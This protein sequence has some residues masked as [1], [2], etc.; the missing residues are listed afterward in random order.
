MRCGRP[1]T[2]PARRDLNRMVSAPTEGLSLRK[3][4]AWISLGEG[5]DLISQ[6]GLLAVLSKL[7]DVGAVGLFGLAM[8]VI[9]PVTQLFDLGLRKAQAT[10]V[11]RE[12]H[13]NHYFSLRVVTSSVALLL[14]ILVGSALGVSAY[15]WTVVFLMALAKVI[16]GQSDVFHGLF[17]HHSRMDYIA[18][19]RM[20]RGPL[21]LTLFTLG[22]LVTG[23]QRV[24]SLGLIVA[25]FT[26][27][28]LND[29]RLARRFLTVDG[30]EGSQGNL[31]DTGPHKAIAF[32]WDTKRMSALV[33]QVLPLGI[34]AL[35]ASLQMN[36]P[37]YSLEHQLGLEALGYF[38]AVSVLYS[39]TARMAN[40]IA[41]SASASMARGFA[42]GDRRS[43][44]LLYAKLGIMGFLLGVGGVLAVMVMGREILTIL[45]TEAY[46]DYTDILVLVMVAAA[47]RH[48]GS[49]WQL[50]IVAARRFRLHLIQHV[51][52][53][54]VTAVA[55]LLL[56]GP[57]GVAGAAYVLIVVAL[58]NLTIVTTINA[59]LLRNISQ[60]N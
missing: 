38:T 12:Y 23:D 19:A 40:A 49:V 57:Y 55:S 34:V 39:A 11:A 52:N 5:V 17:Q 4:V 15:G 31:S 10:D 16:E 36:I 3:N 54:A 18:R 25:A 42:A 51:G 47:I 2:D 56:I 28:L 30:A 8:A 6:W 14:I 58:I 20:L 45:Y 26:V 21:G 32:V 44:V 53:I 48:L 46:A 41:H 7:M 13:F 29:V 27:L 24:A 9:V 50:A 33:R 22:I 60:G 59:F 43:V 1:A 35:L 37:R